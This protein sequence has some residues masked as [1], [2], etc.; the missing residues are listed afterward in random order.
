MAKGKGKGTPDDLDHLFERNVI[1]EED[2][3]YFWSEYWRR[4]DIGRERLIN[5]FMEIASDNEEL[6]GQALAG[7]V[8][9]IKATAVEQAR[10]IGGKVVRRDKRGRF[11]KRGRSWQAVNKGN[12]KK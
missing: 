3:A 2:Y 5:E 9:K 8:T 12:K 6:T 4:D 11:S 7:T 10:I 1:D